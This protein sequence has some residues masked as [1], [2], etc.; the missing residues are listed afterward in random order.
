[1]SHI[2]QQIREG[3]AGLLD[4]NSKWNYVYEQRTADSKANYPYLIVYV[5]SESSDPETMNTPFNLYRDMNLV[6]RGYYRTQDNEAI[7]DKLD[8]I[9]VAVETAVTKATLNAAL[10]RPV[11]SVYLAGTDF[12]LEQDTDIDHAIISLGFVIRYQTEEGNPDG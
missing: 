11:V 8:D 3:V 6:I 9:A 5:D 10:A 1:M 7:E 4:G 12:E 2:R